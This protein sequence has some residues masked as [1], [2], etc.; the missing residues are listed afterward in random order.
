M[1]SPSCL[2]FSKKHD[3]LAF[4]A[5]MILDFRRDVDNI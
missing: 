1:T 5:E 4:G 3:S 2:K